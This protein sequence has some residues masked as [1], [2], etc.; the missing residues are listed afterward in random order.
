MKAF[1]FLMSCA[2]SGALFGAETLAPASATPAVT[3]TVTCPDGCV[4]KKA[5][6][7]KPKKVK[8]K[9]PEAKVVVKVVEKPVDR[10]VVQ[11]VD[12]IV[13][14]V[15]EK[16]TVKHHNLDLMLGRGTD[17]LAIALYKTKDRNNEYA[18]EHE[19]GLVGGLQYTYAFSEPVLGLISGVGLGGFSNH[20]FF[21]SVRASW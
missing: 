12:K 14:K 5:R 13:E 3:P 8:P 20:L 15:V 4:P 16:L 2:L 1:I 10:V 11:T 19:Y 17:G 7:H 9:C 21:G 6:K 18:I